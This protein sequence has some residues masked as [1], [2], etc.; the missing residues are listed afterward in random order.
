M[1]YRKQT[2]K[3]V[4]VAVASYAKRR[5]LRK[6]DLPLC[7]ALEARGIA[8]VPVVWDDEADDWEQFDACLIRSVSDYHV[9]YREFIEWVQR[10]GGATTLWNSVEMTLWNADKSYLRELALA[11][12]PSIPTHWLAQGS[13]VQL[14]DVL[15]SYGW[16]DA[17]LKPTV[18]LGAQYLHR[19][20]RG[21]EQGQ[22]AL[23]QLLAQDG[24]LVQGFLPSVPERGE[25]SLVFIDGELTHT[26]R[27][28]PGDGDFRVQKSWGGTSERCEPTR[29]E[30]EVAQAALVQLSEAPLYARVD[31][32][33]GPGGTPLL[34]ELELIEP[35]LFFRHEPAAAIRLAD[36]IVARLHLN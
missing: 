29:S 23:E 13:H 31:L 7:D 15:E 11:G 12:V 26:V 34:I 14:A 36:A 10:V 35:D 6:D 25:V 8:P 3:K 33:A 20:R 16:E 21:E 1:T 2:D 27:K 19:V 24:V 4:R 17:V 32:V 22:R 5:P 18:G 30:Q 9:K 28:R